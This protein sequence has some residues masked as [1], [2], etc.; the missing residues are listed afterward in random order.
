LKVQIVKIVLF[1]LTI[2]VTASIIIGCSSSKVKIIGSNPQKWT[3]FRVLADAED[4]P[5]FV[6]LQDNLNIDPKMERYTIVINIR[7]DNPEPYII[8]GDIE[9]S[10]PKKFP[11]S[12]LSKDVQDGLINWKGDNKEKLD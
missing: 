1:S 5:I 12:I 6:K 3:Y 9:E 8:F 4:D 11:W 10:S 7:K 2:L